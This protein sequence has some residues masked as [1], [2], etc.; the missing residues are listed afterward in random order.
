MGQRKYNWRVFWTQTRDRKCDQT[1][2]DPCPGVEPEEPVGS[3]GMSRTESLLRIYY[4]LCTC[5]EVRRKPLL[6]QVKN[7]YLVFR[8][9]WVAQFPSRPSSR[10]QRTKVLE[11]GGLDHG[12]RSST[13]LLGLV[14]LQ[15]LRWYLCPCLSD[16]SETRQS[17]RPGCEKC[18]GVESLLSIEFP[19]RP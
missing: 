19:S 12:F 13:R 4:N 8:F 5:S 3:W 7:K 11:P 16:T 14:V 17:G 9:Q 18:L 1:L 10:V 2:E 15:G 6:D